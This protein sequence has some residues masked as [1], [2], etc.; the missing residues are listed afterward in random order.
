VPR[1]AG[2]VCN[3]NGGRRCN[4]S[5]KCVA[6]LTASDCPGEDSGPSV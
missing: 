6:C 4:G 3:Q 1:A 2:T 5:G